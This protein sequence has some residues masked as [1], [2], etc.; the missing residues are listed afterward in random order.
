MELPPVVT[1]STVLCLL[2]AAGF[3]VSEAGSPEIIGPIQVRRTCRL[4]KPLVLHCDALSDGEEELTLVYWLVNGTF[5]EETSSS[6]R[7]KEVT[8]SSLE[9]GTVIHRSLL[10][11]NVVPEDLRSIFTC[12]VTNTMGMSRKHVRLSLTSGRCRKRNGRTRP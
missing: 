1:V 8:E 7:I 4:G 9:E 5:P 10:L 12:V 6:G 3:P 11:K 2:T